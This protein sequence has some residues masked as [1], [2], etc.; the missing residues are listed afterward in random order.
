[1]PAD[2]Q[3]LFEFFLELDIQ[4]TTHRHAALHTV[5]QS[6]ELRGD[7]PGGHC[8]SLFLKD[9][10]A[11]LWL[12]VA[13]EDREVNLKTLHKQIGSGRL[14]FGKAELMWDILGVRPGSVTPFSLINDKDQQMNVVLDQGMLEFDLLNYHPLHNEATTAISTVDLLRFIDATGH[15]PQRVDLVPGVEQAQ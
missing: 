7:L 6:Q 10:K 1:M 14:S 13:L 12:I 3:Q 8:K 15:T 4:T 11:Q 9:K 2:E 5:E